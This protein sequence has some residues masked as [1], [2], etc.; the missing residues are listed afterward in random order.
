MAR[1]TRLF[2]NLNT[3]DL[4]GHQI[5]NAVKDREKIYHEHCYRELNDLD[6]NDPISL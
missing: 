3:C 5:H 4:C 6:E 1:K 2:D